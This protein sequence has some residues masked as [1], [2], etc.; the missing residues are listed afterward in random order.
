MNKEHKEEGVNYIF[1]II[2]M[3]PAKATHDGDDDRRKRNV[4][5]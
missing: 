1:V 5:T 3:K 2:Y 4:Y